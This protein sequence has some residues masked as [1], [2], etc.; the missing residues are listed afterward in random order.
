MKNISDERLETMLTEYCEADCGQ[1]FVFDPERKREK[2]VPFAR[3]NRTAAAAA[4][5]VLVSVLS[6]T[7]Y[8]LFGNKNAPLVVA[9]PSADVTT[10]T[11]S[12]NGSG[13]SSTQRNGETA[14]TESKSVMEQIIDFLFP[15]PTETGS[16]AQTA[17]TPTEKPS[18]QLSHVTPTESKNVPTTHTSP[19]EGA[20]EKATEK[21]VS[22][23]TEKPIVTPTEPAAQAPTTYVPPT[24]P[25][26]PPGNDTPGD[27]PPYPTE[28]PGEGDEPGFVEPTEGGVMSGNMFEVYASIDSSQLDEHSVI[29]C[30]VYD[31]AGR[32][33]G[34]MD[35]FDASHVAIILNRGAQVTRVLYEMSPDLI[36]SPGTYRFVFYD[37]SGKQLAQ[38]QEYWD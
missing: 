4:S 17:V 28:A 7:V 11:A 38:M 32:R 6:L 33:L 20:G 29:Y 27:D 21:A 30:K 23:P 26:D 22:P 25:C 9:S 2:L 24:V 12:A 18:R 37:D 5:L 14:P 3:I 31:S 34:S 36:D 19:T 8:F 13:G 1:S 15:K 10:P 16:A 35:V